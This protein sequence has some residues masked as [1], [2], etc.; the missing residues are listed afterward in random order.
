MMRTL[1]AKR[2]SVAWSRSTDRCRGARAANLDAS[3]TREQRK[4]ADRWQKWFAVKTKD[5]RFKRELPRAKFLQNKF[6]AYQ[7]A[8]VE[9]NE[10][11]T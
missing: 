2:S 1:A 5:A 10:L 7:Q 8:V 3:T 6:E 11:D 4:E 9:W